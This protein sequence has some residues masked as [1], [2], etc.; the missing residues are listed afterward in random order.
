MMKKIAM[1]LL[2]LLAMPYT[3]IASGE[4]VCRCHWMVSSGSIQLDKYGNCLSYGDMHNNIS[5]CSRTKTD[6]VAVAKPVA[7]PAPVV[8]VMDSD[9]DGVPD[10]LD[11]CADTPKGQMTDATGCPS[12][13]DGDGV[14]D[15][16]DRCP[17]TVA[18]AAVDATGCLA[19]L[20]GDGVLNQFDRC[21]G[22]VAGAVVDATGCL[23]DLDGDGVLNE[24]DRCP[25]TVAGA[26]VDSQGCPQRF[27]VQNL[28]F[29]NNSAELD[30]D[31]RQSLDEVA[32]S[33]LAGAAF[34]SVRVSGFSDNRGNEQYNIDLSA[35][36]AKSVADYLISRG[37]P[38]NQVSSKGFGP[39]QPIADNSTIEG[40][41]T[42]RRVEINIER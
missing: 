4:P 32:A 17:G 26:T 39:Q 38:A 7:T 24:F 40:R 30:A 5:S 27:V 13:S 15:A 31:A 36:R 9:G 2:P 21:P 20:D 3:A 19:D 22:T 41:S 1:L 12:D 42:N 34:K 11:R 18:G 29:A 28:R 37:L 35:R 10:N 8:K 23:A 14:A 33:L 25:G 6:P 16:V